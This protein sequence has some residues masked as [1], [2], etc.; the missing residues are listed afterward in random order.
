M[1]TILSSTRELGAG[2]GKSV[3]GASGQGAGDR[4]I[5]RK[6]PS[7]CGRNVE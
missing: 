2:T 3:T 7:I 1:E 4:S 6:P 5:I